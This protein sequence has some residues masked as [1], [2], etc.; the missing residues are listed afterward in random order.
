MG[1]ND[2][3]TK[4]RI[5]LCKE[6]R[7]AGLKYY[8]TGIQCKNGHVALRRTRDRCCMKCTGIYAKRY[9]LLHPETVRN[10][11][12]KNRHRYAEAVRKRVRLWAKANPRKSAIGKKNCAIKRRGA[13][14]RYSLSDID[15]IFDQQK[16]R[17]AYCAKSLRNGYHIDHIKPLAKG[18]TNYPRNIQ[19][20]CGQ[21]NLC[22]AASDPVDY[23]RLTGRLV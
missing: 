13:D 21:C 7:A 23:A 18:G 15:R 9:K 1:C 11:E 19:L 4:S 22:K 3:I 20:C 6:A 12:K 16:G 8:F 10:W 14:G 5:I 2:P 17:C